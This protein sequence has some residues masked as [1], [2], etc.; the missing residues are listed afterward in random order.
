MSKKVGFLK[1]TASQSTGEIGYMGEIDIANVTGDINKN[2]PESPESIRDFFFQN[3]Y[4]GSFYNDAI[5]L[6]TILQK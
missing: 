4:R 6:S 2:I 3:N 1:E 5:L